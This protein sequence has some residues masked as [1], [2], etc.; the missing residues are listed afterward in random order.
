MFECEIAAGRVAFQARRRMG[1]NPV[2]RLASSLLR[3]KAMP[4]EPVPRAQLLVSAVIACLVVVAPAREAGACGTSFAWF[5]S[6]GGGLWQ[7]PPRPPAFVS[8]PIILMGNEALGIPGGIE[9]E[10][11]PAAHPKE[12]LLERLLTRLQ[13]FGD[14]IDFDASE[15]CALL[16][17][18]GQG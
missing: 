3:A 6:G 2:T 9:V 10:V 4:V 14:F 8:G 13:G 11:T 17:R 7:R 1:R 12:A 16:E 15:L 5:G 18:D